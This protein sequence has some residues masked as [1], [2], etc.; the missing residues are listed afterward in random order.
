MQYLTATMSKESS[1]CL[2]P[3]RL[4]HS[5]CF[6]FCIW[7]NLGYSYGIFVPLLSPGHLGT[8]PAPSPRNQNLF[9]YYQWGWN[10][11]EIL[12]KRN[13]WGSDIPMDP[14]VPGAGCSLWGS[15]RLL[16]RKPRSQPSSTF[17]LAQPQGTFPC[18]PCSKHHI[19]YGEKTILAWVFLR[20]IVCPGRV[21]LTWILD[22][23]L[24]KHIPWMSPG[25]TSHFMEYT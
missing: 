21:D 4:A 14:V 20:W 22:L 3:F 18:S 16:P 23:K 12:F 8:I 24:F 15:C 5:P 13:W 11:P 17:P 1:C 10:C 2:I 7:D 9:I 19:C 25:P 6:H